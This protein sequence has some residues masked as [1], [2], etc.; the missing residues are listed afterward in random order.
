MTECNVQGFWAVDNLK[1]C[2]EFTLGHRNVLKEHGYEHFKSNQTR[3]HNDTDTYVVLAKIGNKPVGGLRF[4]KK[5]KDF[6]VPLE[7]AILPLDDRIL[8]YMKSLLSLSPFEICGL[9]NSKDV[10]GMKLS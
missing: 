9:W 8:E 3:W 4:V 5:R 7:E 10:G 6:L 1:L 2:E